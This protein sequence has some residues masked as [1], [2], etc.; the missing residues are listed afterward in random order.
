MLRELDD[1]DEQMV[2]AL[3]DRR[4]LLAF[5]IDRVLPVLTGPR[6]A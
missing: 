4:P 2:Q 5:V 6:W 3:R 1:A